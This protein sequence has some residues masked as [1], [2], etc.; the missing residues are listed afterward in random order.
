LKQSGGF[1][2]GAKEYVRHMIS[3]VTKKPNY[4]I[5]SND[6]HEHYSVIEYLQK[7]CAQQ[8]SHLA[9]EHRPKKVVSM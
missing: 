8:R 1:S 6:E 4:R 5:C 9:E 2:S 3:S 7:S